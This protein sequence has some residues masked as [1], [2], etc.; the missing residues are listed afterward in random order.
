M[1]DHHPT[2]L[3]LADLMLGD[4]EPGVAA[5]VE[6]CTQCQAAL[7]ELRALKR[8]MR[9]VLRMPGEIPGS[10]CDDVLE[11]KP[12]RVVSIWPRQAMLAAASILIVAG[13]AV[14][15]VQTRRLAKPHEEAPAVAWSLRDGEPAEELA[16]AEE[17]RKADK[18]TLKEADAPDHAATSLSRAGP[19]KPATLLDA[20]RTGPYDRKAAASSV[21]AERKA[22]KAQETKTPA[23]PPAADELL[24]RRP[25][26]K[27]KP[28]GAAPAPTEPGAFG[29]AHDGPRRS[30]RG[31]AAF[32][33]EGGAKMKTRVKASFPAR[34]FNRDGQ[35]D[36]IDGM[37]LARHI[38]SADAA[39]SRGDV[40][41]N[42]A[43]D[44]RDVSALMRH[45]V[46]IK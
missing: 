4:T 46:A 20:V 23:E 12:P 27:P 22:Q 6:A 18:A 41:Q 5:H 13:A 29:R 2:E 9:D 33:S 14:M 35:V 19:G 38:V 25:E 36:V 42:G 30:A 8:A 10:I 16:Q 34:D 31:G 26:P 37:L 17:E 7:A 1:N 39:P 45:I 24:A 43:V 28:P 15:F 44:V 21:D 11:P 40:D 32:K 3:D